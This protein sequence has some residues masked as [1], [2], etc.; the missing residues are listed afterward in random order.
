VG[1][2]Q[3]VA[4][5]R[6]LAELLASVSA[7]GAV[8]SGPPGVGKTALAAAVAQQ[9]ESTGDRVERL[10]ATEASRSI[11]FGT[12]APLLPDDVAPLH[13]AL[14]LGAIRRR[15][16]QLGGPRSPL[17]VVDD[18]HLLDDHSAATLLGLVS[19]GAARLV[20]TVRAGEAAPDAVH[21]LW[22]DGFIAHH[23]VAPFDRPATQQFLATIL[24]G[25]VATGTTSVLWQHTRGNALYLTELAR[26]ARASHRLVSESGVWIWHGGLSVPPRLAELLDRRFDGLDPAGLDALGALVLG[27]PLPI[28]ALEDIATIAGVAELEARQVVMTEERDGIVWYRFAHPMLGAA[29][30]NRLT[31]TRRRRLADALLAAPSSGADVVRRAMWQ[32]DTST[33]PD[34][35]LLRA[36]ASAVFLT[37]PDLARRLVERALP[38][39][40]TPLSALLLADAHAELGQI[41]AARQAQARAKERV[42]S[43][44]DR[45]RVRLNEVSLTAFSD[46]RPDRG[47]EMLAA[48]RAE[49]PAALLADVDSMAA[50]LTVFS[51]RP[52]D[53]L[54]LA[55]KMLSGSPPRASAIRATS[56]RILAL[57]LVDRAAEA[58]ATTPLL[59]ADLA[60]G[61]T[62]PYSQGIAH[63]AAQVARF[64]YW[65]DQDAP[66]TDPSGRWPVPPAGGEGAPPPDSVFHPLFDGSRRLLQ[67]HVAAAVA[68]L[69]EAVAQ[70]RSGEG[71]L[72]SEAVA[73]LVVALA[74]IGNVDEAAQLMAES[75]PDRVAV[76]AGLRPWAQS[77]LDA[78]AG[79]PSAVTEAFEAYGQA[80]AAGSP[81]SAVAYLAAAAR[82][83]A[84][85]Q[86]AAELD[87]WGHQFESP[88][89]DARAGGVRA[90]ATGD[91]AVLLAAAER[92]AAL[93]LLGDAADLAGLAMAAC[94]NLRSERGA[95][96]KALVDEMRLR[97]R[98]VVAAPSPVVPLTR[99][100]LE[101]ASLAARGMT[102]Q[103]IA[104][105]LVISVRTVESHLAAVYRKLGINSRRGLREAL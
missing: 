82:Y 26:D 90:R 33:T 38:H 93:G 77:A 16:Q 71:L 76:Y 20:A 22:K 11:S 95:R 99:R 84:S 46:R 59:F 47:L 29:A 43:N 50:Q 23:E 34:V 58:L 87:S 88:I 67:G 81:I 61:P 78:A 32:L 74:A 39:D 103:D 97:L 25:E 91:A 72:R 12:L 57:A 102:D 63:I 27:E 79:Q 65:A 31:P 14:V 6:E 73:M 3:L 70:Q 98:Q 15:Q 101:V 18:A 7:G 83:G 60:A 4:R 45:L 10:V 54:V 64:V 104:G 36:G 55:E 100:E 62:S 42:R 56:A 41:D 8:L 75:P 24:G 105:T 48:A 37:Q 21:A 80:R 92:H 69:R 52:A 1:K 53:A 96:A 9:V 51:A 94:G 5:E 19:T 28:A 44:D 85:A 2:Q 49:T 30:A 66:V 17:L 40:P 89:S 13:P 86:A 68:P 35:E